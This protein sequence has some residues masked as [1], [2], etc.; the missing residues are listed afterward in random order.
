MIS[1][2]IQEQDATRDA[3][4]VRITHVKYVFMD[5]EAFTTRTAEGQAELVSSLNHIVR[6]TLVDC[7]ITVDESQG[8]VI[9]LPTGDGVCVAILNSESYDIHVRTALSIIKYVDDHN[10]T[11]EN[12]ELTFRV[13]IGLSA[14]DD[15]IVTDINGR[16]NVAGT[17]INTASRI[18]NLADGGMI[19]V[20]DVV[21]ANINSRRAYR[22]KFRSFRAVVKHGMKLEVHQLLIDSPG[23]LHD[24]P[25]AFAGPVAR[26]RALTRAVAWHI[27]LAVKYR[28]FIRAKKSDY[29][30]TIWLWFS[31]H[32]RVIREL[33][34]KQDEEPRHLWLKDVADAG[35]D[36]Q[37]NYCNCTAFY[38]SAELA[39]Y[40]REVEFADYVACIKDMSGTCASVLDLAKARL[41]AEHPDIF[42]WAKEP[43]PEVKIVEAGRS[44]ASLFGTASWALR[45]TT[46]DGMPAPNETNRVQPAHDSNAQ[47]V[48]PTRDSKP[49]KP[50]RKRMTER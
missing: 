20:S 12:E 13:R 14:A 27:G 43:A 18:M 10:R 42:A 19:L 28:E 1:T 37:W 31:A 4:S 35:E 17:G 26:P 38:V 39:S 2:D 23:L 32:D 49:R 41:E 33:A 50:A 36:E 24:V 9:L 47:S 34:A 44:L 30:T 7:G 22:S 29:V 3:S 25:K 45:R 16:A 11:N 46:S 15:S 21:H 8:K 5:I 48:R 40:I 6:R